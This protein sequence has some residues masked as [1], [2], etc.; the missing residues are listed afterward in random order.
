MTKLRKREKEKSEVH[1]WD[2]SDRAVKGDTYRGYDIKRSKKRR[3]KRV[4]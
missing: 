2:G 4:T 1:G 3:R